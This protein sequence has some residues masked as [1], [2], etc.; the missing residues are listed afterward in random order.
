MSKIDKYDREIVEL[1]ME[2]GRMPAAE[3][4][5]RVDGIS[6]RVARYRIE[7]MVRE[8]IITIC[9]IPH[10]KA[11]GYHVVADVFIEVEP[12]LIRQVASQLATYECVSYVACSIGQQDVSV[13]VVAENTAGIYA[14]ATEVIGRL[15]GVRKTV[16]SIVPE[17]M[18][19]VYQWHIPQSE[20]MDEQE[21]LAD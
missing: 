10:P 17:V 16:T 20:C 1:L 3:I 2:D 9:A 8:G 6:E 18:K 21:A 19:D 11:F 7:R 4:A 14:F 12:G 13:Q 15:T 5:R